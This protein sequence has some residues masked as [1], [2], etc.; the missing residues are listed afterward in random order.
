MHKRFAGYL[1]WIGLEELSTNLPARTDLFVGMGLGLVAVVYITWKVLHRQYRTDL[2]AVTL[3]PGNGWR[4]S[5]LMMRVWTL[6]KVES[7]CRDFL[8]QPHKA[9]EVR[10]RA[11]R[12]LRQHRVEGGTH[13]ASWNYWLG[14]EEA[15]EL[16]GADS[17]HAAISELDAEFPPSWPLRCWI[18]Y[19]QRREKKQPREPKAHILLPTFS[20]T[21]KSSGLKVDPQLVP[22]PAPLWREPLR[23][24]YWIWRYK[25]RIPI[26]KWWWRRKVR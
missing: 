7:L 22:R 8:A 3:T 10:V 23:R 25:I 13:H 16:H 19:R 6:R 18:M 4:V 14:L 15:V 24:L 9:D 1:Q 21:L 12:A 26:R 5:R 11:A 20:G 17:V 2:K